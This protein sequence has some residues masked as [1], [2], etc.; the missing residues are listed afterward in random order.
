MT[1]VTVR[2]EETPVAVSPSSA[3]LLLKNEIIAYQ[4]S[5]LSNGKSVINTIKVFILYI[6]ENKIIIFVFYYL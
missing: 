3:Q 4:K 1:R 6:F 5:D 2:R